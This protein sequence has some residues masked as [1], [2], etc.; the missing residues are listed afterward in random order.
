MPERNPLALITGAAQRIGA[1]ICRQLHQADY[2][3]VLH[4][5]SSSES[6]TALAA[7]L[8]ALRP[9]SCSLV[10]ADLA[11]SDQIAKLTEQIDH[12]RLRLLVN[13]ASVYLPTPQD[14]ANPTNWDI[15]MHT[16]LR[17]PWLLSQALAP[18][19]GQNRGNIVNI[20]DAFAA[21]PQPGYALY[22]TA[23]NGLASLT[24]QL[25]LE[26][27]PAVRVNGVAPGAI[28]WPEPGDAEMSEAERE[29]LLRAIPLGR[30]GE[31]EDIARCVLFLAAEAP[32]V[33]GQ[34]LAVDGGASLTPAS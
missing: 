10:K 12:S 4:Y 6:A 19:L 23:K 2:D 1:A 13:N 31:C 7:Q 9:D 34:I 15:L 11:E 33:T 14:Q 16:N 21:R 17:A 24:R 18:V 5:R 28:L 26:L 25:A 3:L 29:S 22:N 20:I 8:N 32:Y 27:A 30:L